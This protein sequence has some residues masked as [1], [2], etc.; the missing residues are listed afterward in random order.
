MPGAGRKPLPIEVVSQIADRTDGVPLFVEELT[1]SV[2]ES[3]VLRE[4]LDRYVLDRAFLPAESAAQRVL[5]VGRTS[6]G[7][8]IWARAH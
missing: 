1:K 5:F 4:D 7:Y 3:G 2:L 8:R 6:D